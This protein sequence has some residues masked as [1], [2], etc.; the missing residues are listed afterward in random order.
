[1]KKTIIHLMLCLGAL[2]LCGA[3]Q[4]EDTGRDGEGAVK[5]QLGLGGTR[6]GIDPSAYPWTQCAIRVYR[7]GA[8]EGAARERL[9]VRRYASVGEMPA[10]L[11]LAAGDYVISVE[12]GQQPEDARLGLATWDRMLY[13]GERDF[14]IV[15]G[16]SVDVAVECRVANT[17]VEVEYDKTVTDLFTEELWTNVALQEKYDQQEVAAGRVPY[18]AF[19]K[20]KGRGYFILPEGSEAFSWRFRG[21]GKM[22]GEDKIVMVDKTKHVSTLPGMCYTLRFKYSPDLGGTLSFEIA[23]SATWDEYNDN[24][25]F[26]PSPQISGE[27][28]EI[29]ERQEFAS[30]TINYGITAVSN[31]AGVTLKVREGGSD[32]ATRAEPATWQ[33]PLETGTPE[34]GISVRMN[35]PSDMLLTLGAEFFAQLRGGDLELIFEVVDEDGRDSEKSSL[36]RTQG[37][38]DAETTDAWNDGAQL[39]AYVFD[40]AAADVKILYR[41]RGTEEWIEAAA[42]ATTQG[43]VYAAPATLRPNTPYECRLHFGQKAVNGASEQRIEVLGPQVSNAGFERWTGSSPLLPYASDADQWWD[44]GNHGSATLKKNVTTNVEDPRPGSSG[45]T[46]AKLQ[47]QHVAMLGIG[48][49]AAGNIFLGKYLGTDGTDGV[50]GFGKPF[51]FTYRPRKLTF[52]YKGSVGTVDYA[53]GA[54]GNGDSDVSQVYILLCKTSGPH[55]VKTRKGNEDTFLDFSKNSKT[56]T[57]CSAP[58]GTD[59][60]NDR[61]DGKIIA[62]AEWTNQVSTAEWKQITLT[63]HYNEEYEGEVPTY[64]M[65]TASASKYGDYFAG[66]TGSVMYLDDFELVY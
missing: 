4:K 53:G 24:V 48:K 38:F 14:T 15:A 60:G 6:A 58:N 10:S 51:D 33:I 64:L 1:M 29:G 5:V 3:C 22:D 8:G 28:F 25:M 65:L 55:V 18:L 39:R 36:L 41:E 11:W 17:I 7:Y 52:W 23:V 46:A 63:L 43:G 45:S 42:A 57:Y 32:E 44:T 56:I 62:W 35:T 9:L 61:T 2:L 50:I 54:V 19:N 47:S 59:S 49:F 13:R 30:G 31:L 40:E 27:G 21:V 37:V 12:L 20:E 66:S 16:R 34:R 26:Q